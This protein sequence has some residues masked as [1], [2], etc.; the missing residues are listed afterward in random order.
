MFSYSKLTKVNTLLL[1][2]ALVSIFVFVATKA[3]FTTSESSLENIF[4]SGSIDVAITQ[5]TIVSATEWMPGDVQ[6]LEFVVKNTGTMPIY[7]KAYLGGQWVDQNL[8]PDMVEI[9]SIEKLGDFG[10]EFLSAIPV[11]ISHEFYAS[12]D[13]TE[14]TI[15]AIF[16]QEENR[17]KVTVRLK[18]ATPD[19]YQNQSF[20]TQLHVAGKQAMNGADWPALY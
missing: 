4:V 8:D 9:V 2:V 3:Y 11:P 7:A 10:W 15:A 18:E 6:V 16:P 19:E 20:T 17:F 5:D 14:D 1:I 13:G 12:A